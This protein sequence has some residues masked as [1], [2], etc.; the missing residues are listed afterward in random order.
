MNI[1]YNSING[2]FI[3]LI[4]LS[5]LGFIYSNPI[6]F[7]ILYLLSSFIGMITFL[8]FK[9]YDNSIIYIY[10]FTIFIFY[11]IGKIFH[12]N[13]SIQ[14]LINDFELGENDSLTYKFLVNQK[15]KLNKCKIT[16]EYNKE[17]NYNLNHNM[18]DSK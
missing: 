12:N 13:Y 5:F 17:N 10:L 2:I 14:S 16:G 1:G 4:L 11:W 3:L 18:S 7:G 8:Y 15:S 6:I 9:K